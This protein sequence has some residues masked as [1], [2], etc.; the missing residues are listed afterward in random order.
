MAIYAVTNG[1]VVL[2]NR[3]LW[4]GVILIEDGIITQVGESHNIIIPSCAHRIDA[5]GAYVGPGFVDIHV[6]GG[7]GYNTWE[8]PEKTGEYF[9]RHGTTSFLATPS[10]SRSFDIL[11]NGIKTLNAA[12]GKVKNLKG[13]F[14]EGPYFNTNYGANAHKNPWK[15]PIDPEQYQPLVDLAGTNAVT[16]MIAPERDG[17]RQFMQYARKVNPNIIFTVGHS[18]ATPDQI[19]SLGNMRPRI[20]THA[21]DATGRLNDG[22]GVR[23]SGPDEY[24]FT[25][26]EMYAELISDSAAIHVTPTNQQM[27]L[28]V[29]GFER[30]ILIT[31][32]T[33]YNNPV[34]EKYAHIDDLNF[35]DRGGLAG[36]K[37]TMNKAC[38]NVMG[39]TGCGICHAFLMA[40]TNPARAVGLDDVGSIEMGKKAD[41]VFVDDKFSVQQVMLEGKICRF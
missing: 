37:L 36:S 20:L 13:Y 1:N 32:G 28:R 16:W 30:V 17:V 33:A 15:G 27:L 6:H 39:S 10:G 3:I 5:K 4:N 19:H 21:M 7:N 14:F 41:L 2:E 12:M 31:D 34:P 11:L 24:C 9:L 22:R 18:E 8:E 38:R 23:G 35:D 26:P 40:A 25:H 29:K